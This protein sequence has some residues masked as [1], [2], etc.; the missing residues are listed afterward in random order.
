M[1]A[2]DTGQVA[3]VHHD[4]SDYGRFVPG[5]MPNQVP[6]QAAAKQFFDTHRDAYDFLVV[7]PVFAFNLADTLPGRSRTAKSLVSTPSCVT[8]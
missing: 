6:R 5:G 3:I 4:G 8:T 7:F 1:L 2:Q